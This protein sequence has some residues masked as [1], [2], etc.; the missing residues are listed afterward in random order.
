MMGIVL[1]ASGGELPSYYTIDDWVEMT[2]SVMGN[3]A[4]AWVDGALVETVP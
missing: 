2:D 3:H 4:W 1:D